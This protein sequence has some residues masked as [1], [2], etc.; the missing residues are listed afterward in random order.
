[1]SITNG[2]TIGG[3]TGLW[4]RDDSGLIQSPRI[5]KPLHGHYLLACWHVS[6]ITLTTGTEEV[7]FKGFGEIEVFCLTVKLGGQNVRLPILEMNQ[8]REHT[9]RTFCSFKRGICS[10]NRKGGLDYV[11]A[12]DI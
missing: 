3:D 11:T 6:C 8:C 7:L 4:N 9:G 5:E 2:P 10:Q 1:M 12:Y